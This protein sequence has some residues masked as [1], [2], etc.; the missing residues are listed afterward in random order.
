M[1]LQHWHASHGR[2]LDVLVGVTGSDGFG[3]HAWL[4]DEPAPAR[5]AE[6]FRVSP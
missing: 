1:L 2:P 3:A 5:F 4:E 6:L